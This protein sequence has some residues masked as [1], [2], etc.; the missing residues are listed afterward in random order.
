MK[1]YRPGTFDSR[2]IAYEKVH[3]ITDDQINA[4]VGAVG[5]KPNQ[6]VLDGCAGYGSVTKW[7]LE[8]N[9]KEITS[10]CSFFV[11]DDSLVQIERA[12]ENLKEHKDIEYSVE[13]IKSLPYKDSFFDIV[14]VKMGLHENQ[15]EVQ[16]KIAQEIFRVLK[17]GGRFIVWELFLNEK[18]QPIFQAFMHKKDELA[19][20]DT[21]V[22]KRYFPR[23]DEI[24]GCLSGAGFINFKKELVFNPFLST[25]ARF[26][27][28]ISRELKESGKV[29]ADE[30]LKK[31]ASERLDTLNNFFRGL[32]DEQKQVIDFEDRGDTIIYYNIDK[33]IVSVEK[34]L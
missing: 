26:D 12:K 22:T 27:E 1:E 3:Q 28:L 33:A 8:K 4:L 16:L 17:P 10:T 32:P 24:E 23:G 14:V 15:K 30:H 9:A 20:F 5:L 21:L 13:D 7:L 25:K 29:E 6:K 19:G 31:L 2:I 11:Q 18:T 34:P